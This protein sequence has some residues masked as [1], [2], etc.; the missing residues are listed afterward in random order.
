[1]VFL[2]SDIVGT[3]RIFFRFVVR[4]G[5]GKIVIE[6]LFGLFLLYSFGGVIFSEV[7]GLGSWIVSIWGF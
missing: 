4:G 3:I 2:G 5:D 1:M 7:F 6:V